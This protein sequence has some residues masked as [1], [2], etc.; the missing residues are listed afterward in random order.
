MSWTEVIDLGAD[1]VRMKDPRDAKRQHKTVEHLLHRFNTGKPTERYE[2]QV[3]ADEV[4]MGKTF[5]A[6]ATAFATLEAQ[7]ADADRKTS[8][9]VLVLVPNNDA[10]FRKWRREAKEFVQRCVPPEHRTA[11]SARFR[12]ETADRLDDVAAG[13]C[14]VRGPEIVLAKVSALGGRLKNFDL[15]ARFVLA[16]AFRFWA[17]RFRRDARERLLRGSNKW[18]W[19]TD[20][21]AFIDLD[22]EELAKGIPLKPESLARALERL[23]RGAD[24]EALLERCREC[25]TLYR[26]GREADSRR[27]PPARGRPLQA[28]GGG[29][30]EAEHPARHRRRSAQLEERSEQ[31]FEQLQRVRRVDCT[32]SPAVA[33]PHRHALPAA[34]RGTCGTPQGIG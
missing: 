13:L 31:G 32:E 14:H 1:R 21:R 7:R 25:A 19:P 5:V 24:G 29:A 20:P 8:P 18:Q 11:V 34:P 9:H 15:K 12:L 4:G 16:T 33:L 26:R 3:L 27:H 2:L 17:G 6:L 22:P 23:L 30:R 10:L 28:S